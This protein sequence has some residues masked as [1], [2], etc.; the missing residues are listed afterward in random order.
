[1]PAESGMGRGNQVVVCFDAGN[2]LP[3]VQ[4]IKPTGSVVMA[5]DND[6]GTQAK[7]GFNPGL[8]KATNAAELIGAGVAYPRGIEGTDWADFLAQVGEGAARKAER[9]ILGQAKYVTGV[10]A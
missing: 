9:L 2:L 4:R 7:R 3:V 1:M 10:A 8:E 5:A 6:I